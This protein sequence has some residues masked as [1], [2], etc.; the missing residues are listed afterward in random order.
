MSL[1]PLPLLALLLI[2]ACRRAPAPASEA[3]AALALLDAGQPEQAVTRARALPPGEE[4]D[5]LLAELTRRGGRN[6]C[7]EIADPNTRTACDGAVRRPHLR[8]PEFAPGEASGGTAGP[9]QGPCASQAPPLQDGCLA[10]AAQDLPLAQADAACAGIHD[11]ERRGDCQTTVALRTLADGSTA[12]ARER[13]TAIESPTRQQECF[14]QV[15]DASPGLTVA[16]HVDLC[17][18]AGGFSPYCLVHQAN[19]AAESSLAALPPRAT[20]AQANAALGA[21]ADELQGELDRRGV[22]NDTIQR[23]VLTAG[24]NQLMLEG[25]ISRDPGLWW[26]RARAL[27]ALPSA[28]AALLGDLLVRAWAEDAPPGAPDEGLSTWQARLAQ[29]TQRPPRGDPGGPLLRAPPER[30][31]RP[32]PGTLPPPL[33]ADSACDLVPADRRAIALLWGL[34]RLPWRMNQRLVHD[35]LRHPAPAVRLSELWRIQEKALGWNPKEPVP[36]WVLP[37]LEQAAATESVPELAQ[38]MRQLQASLPRREHSLEKLPVAA[39]CGGT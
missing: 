25:R 22:H 33:E 7:G 18:D 12:A 21:A 5:L 6:L 36:D 23:H 10:S 8:L 32:V 35:A 30:R 9:V 19:R 26:A 15:A 28:Q 11:P 31:G 4:R 2:A 27:P 1:P 20:F 13:C 3:E 24:W 16:D 14:F 38:A 34:G 29:A 37:E 39:I 17:V